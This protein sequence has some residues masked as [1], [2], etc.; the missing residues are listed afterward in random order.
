MSIFHPLSR[1]RMGFG[2]NIDFETRQQLVEQKR[3]QSRNQ[4]KKL[5][6]NVK[7]QDELCT[8]A[9]VKNIIEKS[10]GQAICKGFEVN[11]FTEKMFVIFDCVG[12]KLEIGL[13]PKNKK[14]EGIKL[15]IEN[16]DI[17]TTLSIHS[18]PECII[19]FMKDLAAWL[20]EYRMI[21]E[22]WREDIKKK[23]LACDIAYDV[24]KRNAEQKLEE[25]GYLFT[26]E[27]THYEYQAR[28]IIRL[29]DGVEIKIM[30]NL[31]DDFL[32]EIRSILDSLP[33]RV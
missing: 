10:D 31:L 32:E 26:I 30:V 11:E 21:E 25:K 18:K 8:L 12:F 15:S 1:T 14:N 4:L 7:E 27:N 17:E 2:Y 13:F 29:P 5:K 33:S 16:E 24:L 22:K 3:L 23:E 6:T 9:E 20:P 28:I 19:Q